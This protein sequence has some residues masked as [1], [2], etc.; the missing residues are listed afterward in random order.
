MGDA[1][2][3]GN[4]GAWVAEVAKMEKDQIKF[5][6]HF[7]NIYEKHIADLAAMLRGKEPVSTFDEKPESEENVETSEPSV[8]SVIAPVSAPAPSAANMT[9]PVEQGVKVENKTKDPDAG[10]AAGRPTR[11]DKD[12]QF[13]QL[14]QLLKNLKPG[15][16]PAAAQQAIVNEPIP[17]AVPQEVKIPEPIKDDTIPV[18]EPIITPEPVSTKEEQKVQA[19]EVVKDEVK[20]ADVKIPEVKAPEV[21]APETKPVAVETPKRSPGRPKVNKD[22]PAVSVPEAAPESVKSVTNKQKITM[23]VIPKTGGENLEELRAAVYKTFGNDVVFVSEQNG[24]DKAKEYKDK[25]YELLIKKYD[26]VKNLVKKGPTKEEVFSKLSDP[27]FIKNMKRLGNGDFHFSEILEDP[28]FSALSTDDKKE[29]VLKLKDIRTKEMEQNI[30]ID[31]STDD[32]ALIGLEEDEIAEEPAD[33][34]EKIFAHTGQLQKLLGKSL[35]DMS[36]QES[37]DL[38]GNPKYLEMLPKLADGT[39][40]L[41]LIK[42]FPEYLVHPEEDRPFF[43][44]PLNMMNKDIIKKNRKKSAHIDFF[45]YFEKVAATNDA[46]LMAA[47][48][49]KY[50]EEIDETDPETSIK[51]LQHAQALI[52]D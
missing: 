8:D 36:L 11:G 45:N 47:V 1:R 4:I 7:K 51:L 5:H 43:I 17:K 20:P 29:L 26:D 6:E 24:Y 49:C 35:K 10:R 33:D 16:V 32:P 50:S 27:E 34:E 9:V 23:V 38:I 46:G 14:E 31:T 39:F 21:K 28:A 12:K 48:L 22:A 52:N 2:A 25:G 3:T 41:D 19:P 30:P 15:D 44:G 37:Y 18:A 40:N 13:D 42:Q